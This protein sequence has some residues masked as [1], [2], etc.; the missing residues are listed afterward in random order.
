VVRRKKAYMV[1]SQRLAWARLRPEGGWWKSA[2]SQE[3]LGVA[4][5]ARRWMRVST[6]GWGKQSR[7]KWVTMRSYSAEGRGCWV[8]S[9]WMKVVRGEGSAWAARA[10]MVGLAS[11]TSTRAEGCRLRK[12]A[13]KRPS[14]S[15]RMR[16]RWGLGMSLM[17]R[18]RA[19][20]SALP[21]VRASRRW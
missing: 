1:V 14:P 9:A 20:W 11:M 8:A 5:W 13:R 17:N 7:K 15:P 4:D 10:S 18:T 16:T 6:W 21:K 2:M 12:A 19:L 3:A